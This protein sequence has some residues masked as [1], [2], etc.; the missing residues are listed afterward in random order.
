MYYASDDKPDRQ[1]ENDN[2]RQVQLAV[3]P[4]LIDK[5]NAMGHC[6]RTVGK[7]GNALTERAAV[8]AGSPD[9]YHGV[10]S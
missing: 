10:M 4:I 5:Q 3:T 2:K 7:T 8:A 9:A 6:T 1:D